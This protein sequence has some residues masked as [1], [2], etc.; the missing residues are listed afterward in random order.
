MVAFVGSIC[1]NT[2]QFVQNTF[3]DSDKLARL[4]TKVAVP[5]FALL[6]GHAFFYG[7]TVAFKAAVVGGTLAFL[8]LYKAVRDPLHNSADSTVSLKRK[9]SRR[10]DKTLQQN[11][12]ALE[13][14]FG[15][16]AASTTAAAKVKD[17]E[18][19]ALGKELEQARAAAGLSDQAFTAATKEIIV[20]ESELDIAR[21]AKT[22]AEEQARNSEQ[23]RADLEARIKELEAANADLKREIDTDD[24]QDLNEDEATISALRAQLNQAERQKE[25]HHAKRRRHHFS[26]RT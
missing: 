1:R 17:E 22:A 2:N 21:Q 15:D 18:L 3:N 12:T 23:G 13:R 10:A 19:A 14:R 9:S 20:L 24:H 8:A 4:V 5:A 16:L 7:A 6:T 11:L 26:K 25:A